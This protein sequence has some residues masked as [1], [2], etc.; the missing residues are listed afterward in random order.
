[1]LITF[2]DFEKV[3]IRVGRIIKMEPS[4][5]KMGPETSEALILGVPD[6][7]DMVIRLRP[8]S[9]VQPSARVF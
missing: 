3:D 6:S 9:D 7:H 1:M 2:N 4:P 5:A 8:D